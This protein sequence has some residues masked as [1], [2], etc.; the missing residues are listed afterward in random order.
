MQKLLHGASIVAILAA[1]LAG[2]GGGDSGDTAVVVPPPAPPPAAMRLEDQFGAN[3]G[4]AFRVAAN[5]DP[6]NP[7][8]T[9]LNPVSFVTDPIPVP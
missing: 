7:Q 3:F 5:S 8:P 6:S 9:D 4:T 1:G 2:C